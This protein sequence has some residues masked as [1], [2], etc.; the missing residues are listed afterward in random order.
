MRCD[1]TAKSFLTAFIL[2]APAL[3]T[4]QTRSDVYNGATCVS[5]PR[6]NTT[7]AIPF[8][9]FLYGFKE[10]ANCHI[11]MPDGWGVGDLSYVL[12]RGVSR[13]E[14]P[15]AG[16]ALCL[17]GGS[18]CRVRSRKRPHFEHHRE[19]GCSPRNHSGVCERCLPRR[20][21]SAR[22]RVHLRS[23]HPGVESIAVDARPACLHKGPLTPRADPLRD[24]SSA[25]EPET[26]SAR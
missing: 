25:S 11:T 18:E 12:F 7:V 5:Y 20:E 17:R 4:A 21:V 24:R 22:P 10:S 14:R 9:Y 16:P 1:L 26:A 13:L 8:S 3:A 19:L 23:V 2:L 15:G 6:S